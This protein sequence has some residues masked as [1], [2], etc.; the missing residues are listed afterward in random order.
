VIP[1]LQTPLG[2]VP[3]GARRHDL[4]LFGMDAHGRRTLVGVEAKADEPFDAS[5]KTRIKRAQGER[6]RATRER[7]VYA[8][9]QIP[10]IERFSRALFGRDAMPGGAPDTVVGEL[11]YQLLA[12]LAGTLIEAAACGADQVA[13]VVHAFHSQRLDPDRV[14]ANDAGPARMTGWS[15]IPARPF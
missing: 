14:A 7:R 8:S 12:G 2:D 1:E 13:F 3:R 15:P 10:R 4:V 5:V 11:P 9:A 6:D